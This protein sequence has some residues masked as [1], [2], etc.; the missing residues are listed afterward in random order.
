MTA[1]V[2]AD[3]GRF[4]LHPEVRAKGCKLEARLSGFAA[5]GRKP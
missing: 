2:G 3:K 1:G 5:E 4:G